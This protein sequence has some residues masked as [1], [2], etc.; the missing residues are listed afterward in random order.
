M[1]HSVITKLT[2]IGGGIGP[3]GVVYERPVKLIRKILA[4][5][6]KDHT[7]HVVTY[8][9]MGNIPVEAGKAL[10]FSIL[11]KASQFAMIDGVSV[12]N[13]TYIYED[14]S[15]R[16]LFD[17]QFDVNVHKRKN[18]TMVLITHKSSETLFGKKMEVCIGT[19][20]NDL[21]M[22]KDDV[23]YI[24]GSTFTNRFGGVGWSPPAGDYKEQFVD[25]STRM[26]VDSNYK[27]KP[28]C[29]RLK[30]VA[31]LLE[32]AELKTT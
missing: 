21:Y 31:A 1:D 17:I 7:E 5:G 2:T 4:G 16:E 30:N 22:F 25:Y 18:V 11:A 19:D 12:P 20:I 24:A 9:D 32:H 26:F 28:I 6:I 13:I 27:D 29:A 14:G 3:N 15:K 10:A 23:M 8:H